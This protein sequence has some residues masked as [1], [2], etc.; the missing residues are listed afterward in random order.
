MYNITFISKT[1]QFYYKGHVF[2]IQA[3]YKYNG[4]YSILFNIYQCYTVMNIYM[5]MYIHVTHALTWDQEFSFLTTPAVS[6]QL[7]LKLSMHVQGWTVGE[8]K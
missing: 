5:N 8:P 7:V 6:L 1:L 4:I 3:G 2:E